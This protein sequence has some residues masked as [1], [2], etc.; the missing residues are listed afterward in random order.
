MRPIHCIA[1]YSL[2]LITTSCQSGKDAK[3][4]TGSTEELPKVELGI[5]HVQD[6]P[7]IKTYT[8][9]VEA[10]NTNNI[11]PS[12]PNRIKTISVEVG[13]HVRQGQILVTLDRANID[14]L[15]VNLDNAEREYNRAVQLLE[16]GAGTQQS[17]DQL[18]TQLDATR[19]QYDNL[20]EN[21]VLTSPISGIV[22]ARNYDP[23]DMTGSQPVLTVGQITPV[24]KVLI[25]ITENDLSSIRNGMPVTTTFD[26][27]PQEKFNGKISRIHPTVDTSTRTFLAEILINNT[28]GRIIPGMFARV[29]IDLGEKSNVVVPDRAVVKQSGSGNKYVY[30]YKSGK[31]SYNKVEIGQRLGDSYELLSGVEN[32]DSVVITGQSRLADGISVDVIHK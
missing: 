2:I 18:K 9:N 19:T 26:A 4:Q 5:A 31:V 14:Q 30:V 24:V 22:T 17:V 16:I 15:K 6:V 12:T 8:A 23:G 11:S 7:Q 29:E 10:D 27:Y 32:G 25:N 28:D 3:D 13:D 20:M 1:F 21:T